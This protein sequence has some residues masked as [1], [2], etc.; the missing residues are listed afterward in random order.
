[1]PPRHEPRDQIPV[2]AD[3]L[4]VVALLA[5][6]LAE[7]LLAG[8][9]PP[10]TVTGYLVLYAIS[11]ETVPAAEL[12][13]RA[14]VSGPAV[15]Q[16]LTGLDDAGLILRT[17]VPSDRRWQALAL[18]EEGRDVFQSAQTLLRHQFSGMLGELP[19]PEADA[20]A[21]GLPHVLAALSGSPPP[22]RPPPPPRHGPLA[23][24]GPH[25]KK[26]PHLWADD[27]GDGRR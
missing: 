7:R 15:S 26:H 11:E 22:R 14:G 5:A 25:G 4:V 21:R 6:R 2:A 9:T 8:H 12:A 1:M 3:S 10:L 16:L 19:Q 24:P 17:P 13:R 27:A 23:G 20:L 18:S